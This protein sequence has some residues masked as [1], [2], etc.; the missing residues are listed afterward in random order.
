MA[1]ISVAD[2]SAQNRM[3]A[4]S[5][6]YRIFGDS[7]VFGIGAD[8][9]FRRYDTLV[10]HNSFLHCAAELGVFGLIPWV[11]LLFVSVRNLGYVAAHAAGGESGTR[12]ATLGLLA[13]LLA[14]TLAA[15]FISKTYHALL[16]LFVGLSAAAVNVYIDDT[17][18]RFQL[19]TRRDVFLGLGLVVAGL[20]VFKLFLVV[21]GV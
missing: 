5:T 20:V 1:E 10:A 4:W 19:I 2:P 3:L 9:W 7:P 16:F 6:A 8:A 15:L 12:R 13:G 21:V 11:L 17:G 14:F 18:G